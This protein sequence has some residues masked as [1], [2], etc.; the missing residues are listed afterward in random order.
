MH[1]A[2]VAFSF[3]RNAFG[4]PG[5]FPFWRESAFGAKMANCAAPIAFALWRENAFGAKMGKYTAPNAFSFW[6]EMR[7]TSAFPFWHGD[8]FI[9]KMANLLK[10]S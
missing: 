6:S 1:F 3:S 10:R 4:A 2:P 5:A 9:A 8:A 7:P